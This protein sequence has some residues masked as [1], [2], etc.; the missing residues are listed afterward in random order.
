MIFKNLLNT[1]NKISLVKQIILGLC[2]GI[3]LAVTVPTHVSGISILGELFVGA[4]K[5][6]AP[7]LVF[8]LVMAAI[9]QHKTG[10]KTNMKAIIGLYLI[11]T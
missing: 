7:V 3:L 6:V 2:V 5:A 1:W 8:F 9:S 11:G 4:L 10:Q